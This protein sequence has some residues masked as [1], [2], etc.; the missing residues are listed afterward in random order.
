[1]STILSIIGAILVLSV[2][3]VVHEFGHYGA[4]RLVGIKVLEFAVG[5]GP[6]IFS[7]VRNGITYSIRAFPVGGFCRFVDDDEATKSPDAFAAQ[8]LWKRFVVIFSGA[9]LNII[10]SL[11]LAVTAVWAYGDFAAALVPGQQSGAVW[12]GSPAEAAGL[13]E[14]DVLVS[15]DGHKLDPMSNITE[16]IRA[17]DPAAMEVVVRRDGKLLSHTIQNFYSQEKGHN[18]IGVTTGYVRQSFG[19]SEAVGYSFK[20]IWLIMKE[21]FSFLGSLFRP[22]A[23]VLGNV[24]G[25][26]GTIDIISQAVRLGL[27][28]VIRLAMFVGMSLGIVNLLPIPG[29]DGARLVFIAIEKIRGK[30]IP[31]EKEGIVHFVGLVA[32]LGLMV[33]LAYN[34][35]SRMVAR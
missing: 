4:A 34:D 21:T 35:I 9:F 30:A 14:G 11:L 7:K 27:E 12:P 17:A 15:I 16:L 25:F 29:L 31:P 24:T 10:F 33:L 6:K 5:M 19:F 3:V 18:F 2:L 28:N 23:D 13:K 8:A 1:M 22:N 20:Y 26:V 32:L